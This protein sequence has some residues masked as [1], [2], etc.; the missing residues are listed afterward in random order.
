MNRRALA[1]GLSLFLGACATATETLSNLGVPTRAGAAQVLETIQRG[2]YLVSTLEGERFTL[3]FMFP[4]TP[5]CSRVLQV[6]GLV[7]FTRVGRVG[8]LE[9]GASV[10]SANGIASL[11]AWRDRAAR[12]EV[13]SSDAASTYQPFFVDHAAILARG[14]FPQLSR[15]GWHPTRDTVVMLPRN[16]ACDAVANAS[17]AQLKYYPTGFPAFTLSVGESHCAVIGVADPL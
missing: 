2:G 17:Q 3:S 5:E 13:L 12:F 14:N 1:I 8:D 4:A 9:R 10:C 15:I 7:G 11:E 16:P 6:P